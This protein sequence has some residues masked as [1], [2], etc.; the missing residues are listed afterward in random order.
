MNPAKMAAMLVVLPLIAGC[1]RPTSVEAP[2]D[3]PS[4][5]AAKLAPSQ[6]Q[7][8][9]MKITAYINVTSGCQAETVALLEKLV[10]DHA[11]KV[12]LELIDF[13][14][15]E[16]ADRWRQDGLECMTLLFDGS[17]VLRYPGTEGQSRVV[18]FSMP[19]GFSWT[20]EDLQDA[21][22]AIAQGTAEVL[23]EEQAR[24]ALAPR[25]VDLRTAV[26]QEGDAAIVEINDT[27]VLKI[28]A[29]ADEKTPLDRAKATQEAIDDWA[30]QPIHT[31]QLSVVDLDG[32]ISIAAQGKPIIAVTE[33]DAKAAGIEP[34][35]QLAVEW[36]IAVKRGVDEALGSTTSE[37]STSP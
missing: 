23:T 9:K 15:T 37:S 10:A 32:V 8:E 4:E 26:R 20:H 25:Q 14:S 11:A 33:A 34:V 16:G 22:A 29:G 3:P 2:A 27:P 17:P 24:A 18:R 13:G 7:P 19:A 35:K 12:E 31:S 1:P 5:A 21:F 30:R 36:L 6:A 28:M